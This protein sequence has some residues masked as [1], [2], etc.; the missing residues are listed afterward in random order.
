LR[1]SG[2]RFGE[3]EASGRRHHHRLAR[4]LALSFVKKP[5]MIWICFSWRARKEAWDLVKAVRPLLVRVP[6]LLLTP[7]SSLDESACGLSWHCGSKKYL[8]WSFLL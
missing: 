2:F 3:D 6:M 4:L 7:P 5:A 8:Q 1:S